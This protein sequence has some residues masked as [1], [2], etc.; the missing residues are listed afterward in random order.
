MSDCPPIPD[1]TASIPDRFQVLETLDE[2]AAMQLYRAK[3]TLLDRE[4]F[5]KRPGA[6]LREAY[7]DEELRLRSLREARALASVRHPGVELLLDAIET[8]HGP[9]LVLEPTRGET[10]ETRLRREGTLSPDEIVELGLGLGR[11]LREV[12]DKGI[13]HRGIDANCVRVDEEGRVRLT[14]FQLAKPEGTALK[15]SIISPESTRAA[16]VGHPAPEQILTGANDARADIFALGWLLFESL[17]GEPPYEERSPAAWT[18]PASARDHVP[19][20]PVRLDRLLRA[21]LAPSPSDRTQSADDFVSA[22][23]A[24]NMQPATVTAPAAPRWAS[25]AW[26]AAAACCAA[27]IVIL[28]SG[29][30]PLGTPTRAAVTTPA[31]RGAL[32]RPPAKAE[33]SL[34]PFYQRSHALLIG[35]GDAYREGGFTPLA[36]AER[37]VQAIAAALATEEQFPWDTRL[38]LG[39]R[40]TEDA[41]VDALG[42]LSDRVGPDDRVF[43]YFA[44]HGV[45]HE[46]AAASGWL[47]PSDGKQDRRSSWVHFDHLRRFFQ[48]APA[49]HILVAIDCCY[50]GRLTTTRSA[51]ADRAKAAGDYGQRFLTSPAHVVISS[52]RANEKVSDGVAGANS[53]FATAFLAALESTGPMTSTGLFLSI[54]EYFIQHK[55]GHTPQMGRPE[56]SP[57]D[58]EFV[59]FRGER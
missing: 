53:P 25:A 51:S 39:E 10:L 46:R 58:G 17:T 43:I 2:S 20:T 33:G 8:G 45:P 22:L 30:G 37:D 26:T 47:I 19:E 40:A 4:V 59:F 12:H 23:E 7:C 55:V 11:A 42:L 35:V 27:L 3:D 57:S 1:D 32:R 36:N 31:E 13:I 48:E 56:E 14:G 50:A 6:L 16:P 24:V 21:C 15:S 52:G 54:Q 18:E 29:G 44:G 34:E 5:L 28:V 9:L 41:I 49:K 38:V